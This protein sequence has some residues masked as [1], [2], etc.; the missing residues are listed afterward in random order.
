MG[1]TE[2][3][4]RYTGGEMCWERVQE[5]APHGVYAAMPIE[6]NADWAEIAAIVARHTDE[7]SLI[8]LKSYSWGYGHGSMRCVEELAKRGREIHHHIV[9]DGVRRW[10]YTPTRPKW[11]AGVLNPQGVLGSTSWGRKMLKPI[12]NPPTVRLIEYFR[13]KEN[14]PTGRELVAEDPEKTL[15]LNPT[16]LKLKHSEIDEAPEVLDAVV[17]MV[18][19]AIEFHQDR[20][21]NTLG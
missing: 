20:K 13:Q 15:V 19:K 8:L 5:F 3:T 9:V 7:N 17:A 10:K 2:N 16:W 18:Q 12:S 11:I 14:V 6:W 4:I 21:G 1:Y